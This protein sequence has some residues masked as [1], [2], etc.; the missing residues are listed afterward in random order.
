MTAIVGR[1]GDYANPRGHLADGLPTC[2]R[3]QHEVPAA[4]QQQEGRQRHDRQDAPVVQRQL[5]E[6]KGEVNDQHVDRADD[7]HVDEPGAKP[8]HNA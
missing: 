1:K 5:A 3:E 2:S 4:Q 8:P 6:P 7:G